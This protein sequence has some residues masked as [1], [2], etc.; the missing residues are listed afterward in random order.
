MNTAV[1][2]DIPQGMTA[3]TRRMLFWACFTAIAATSAVFAIRGQVIMDWAREF[4]LNETQKGEILG[5]GLW[6]FAGMIVLASLLVDRVGYGK[7]M[8]F[9]FVCHIASTVILLLAKGYWWLYAGTFLVSVG[10]GAAQA[11]ADPVVASMYRNN[12]TTMLNI[13]H[14]SWPAGMVA[15]GMLGI[16]L[17]KSNLDWHWRIAMLLL[18]MGLYGLFMLGRHFPVHERIAAGVSDREMYRETGAIGLWLVLVFLLVETGRILGLPPWLGPAASVVC[19]LG[20]LAYTRSFGRPM[21][22]FLLV[23]MIPLATTELG[24][25][26]WSTS[27]MEVPMKKMAIHAGWVLVYTS[28]IMMILR[29]C[30][31]PVVRVLTPLGV[32]IAS[33][34]LACAGLV[35]L[36]KATGVGILLAATIYGIGKTYLWPTVLGIVAERFPRGGALSL[37]AVS[38]VGMMS[39]GVAGTV[40]LGLIQD[41][42]VERRLLEEQPALHAQVVNAKPSVLGGYQAVD[43][44][45][46]KALPAA[47]QEVITA[48]TARASQQAVATAAIFPAVMLIGYL[49][50]F[51]LFRKQGGY[52]AVALN[53]NGESP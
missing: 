2:A 35:A 5:V 23:L 6:P 31:A 33:C 28:F 14:A 11:V 37:N 53:P 39:V 7:T 25:D 20:F 8:A 41:K 10:N 19:A 13:L 22:L 12:K 46:A 27:L 34:A 18:P 29:F 16:F 3:T 17:E 36:S 9:A 44:G 48:L 50:L 38:A 32:M 52:K 26:S 40:F 24:I 1:D 4:G 51:L 43:P 21:L 47:D 30:A 45:K 42:A 15:G 49:G